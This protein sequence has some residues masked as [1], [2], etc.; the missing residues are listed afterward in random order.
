MDQPPGADTTD[1]EWMEED[2]V[3]MKPANKA[4]KT[5]ISGL[6]LVV[7][8]LV[9]S[10]FFLAQTVLSVPLA[11]DVGGEECG[12]IFSMFLAVL[13]TVTCTLRYWTPMRKGRLHYISWFVVTFAQLL[14]I[15]ILLIYVLGASERGQLPHGNIIDNMFAT[16]KWW[17]TY[18]TPW[19]TLLEGFASLLVI[20]SI[21]QVSRWL[22]HSKSQFWEMI[23]LIVSGTTMSSALYVLYRVYSFTSMEASNATL[24][25]I[26]LTAT[27]VICV[28]SLTTGKGN[29]LESSFLFGYIVYSIYM[30]TTDFQ[31]SRPLA[32]LT[33]AATTNTVNGDTVEI[34]PFPPLLMNSY[35]SLMRTLTSVLPSTISR[36]L[37]FVRQAATSVTP[38]V[39]VSLAY[40]LTVLYAATRIIPLIRAAASQ[41]SHNGQT[42][43][44]KAI[45]SNFI[46]HQD[47]PSQFMTLLIAYSP[48]AIVNVYTHLLMQHLH[49]I[50][51][52]SVLNV[53]FTSGIVWRWV[54]AFSVLILYTIEIRITDFKDGE[55][56]E[57][58]MS[59]WKVE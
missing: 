50:S 35:A 9:L 46:A 25:G 5:V 36:I 41:E 57:G 27:T 39:F 44:S 56:S 26:A 59:H 28:W 38:S 43:G 52:S 47:L 23:L 24:V 20:Q 34:L 58:I 17:L 45:K 8:R 13:Y 49:M 6:I 30:M 53:G 37:V 4:R 33:P 21:G 1:G 55:M 22:I 16:W 2:E 19:F 14:V 54:S 11:F 15:P 48:V 31:P 29:I 12:L 7:L 40:R 32:S 3:M 51:D 18:S 42:N 10:T